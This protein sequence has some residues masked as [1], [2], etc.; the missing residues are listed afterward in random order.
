[1]GL[2]E[3]I[4]R[5]SCLIHATRTSYLHAKNSGHHASATSCI[6]S[7]TQLVD[8]SSYSVFVY[9]DHG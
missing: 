9:Y 2:S 4:A 6:T 8:A 5:F 3:Y 1:M 7:T